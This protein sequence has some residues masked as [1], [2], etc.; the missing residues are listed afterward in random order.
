LD[1]SFILGLFL[2]F[3]ILDYHFIV[4]SPLCMG[5]LLDFGWLFTSVFLLWVVSSYVLICLVLLMDG[6]PSLIVCFTEFFFFGPLFWECSLGLCPRHN[7]HINQHL[8]KQPHLY[9]SLQTADRSGFFFF[10]FL[11]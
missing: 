1:K 6:F 7:K 9:I 8:Y 4:M 10:N 5:S 3:I 2:F 11:M